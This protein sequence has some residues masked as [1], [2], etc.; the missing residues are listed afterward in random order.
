MAGFFAA[1]GW[2]GAF[3]GGVSKDLSK[4]GGGEMG[5]KLLKR[6][7]CA[8]KKSFADHSCQIG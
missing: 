7:I 4:V 5:C 2:R 8:K 1:N 6:E 3:N